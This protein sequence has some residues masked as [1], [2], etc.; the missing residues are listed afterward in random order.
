MPV[1]TS[2]LSAT[3]AS[4]ALLLTSCCSQPARV[5][6]QGRAVSSQD[7]G[8]L[9]V[10]HTTLEMLSTNEAWWSSSTQ[11]LAHWK[12]L[13]PEF[14]DVLCFASDASLSQRAFTVISNACAHQDL[15][16][17]TYGLLLDRVSKI[18][19]VDRLTGVINFLVAGKPENV[20]QL[21]RELEAEQKLCIDRKEKLEYYL[22]RW[23]DK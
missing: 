7:H 17:W 12:E 8:A 16:F 15:R 11:I 14:V 18:R 19:D 21:Q 6:E 4:V 10:S 5:G 9:F 13:G 23:K 22:S 20:P 2:V 1:S 3:F